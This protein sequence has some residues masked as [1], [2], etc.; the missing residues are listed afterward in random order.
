M[1]IQDK[2]KFD[3][4]NKIY[5]VNKSGIGQQMLTVTGKEWRGG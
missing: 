1:H 2:N 5:K 4:V 3:H